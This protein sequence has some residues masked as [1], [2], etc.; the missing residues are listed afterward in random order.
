MSVLSLLS[1]VQNN[2]F[3]L[4]NIVS[5]RVV[6]VICGCE[7]CNIMTAEYNG[8]QIGK[9]CFRGRTK[10]DKSFVLLLFTGWEVCMP[11]LKW[12]SFKNTTIL[13]LFGCSDWWHDTKPAISRGGSHVRWEMIVPLGEARRI[14]RGAGRWEFYQWCMPSC[15]SYSSNSIIIITGRNGVPVSNPKRANATAAKPASCSLRAWVFRCFGLK[16]S[17]APNSGRVRA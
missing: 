4:P 15:L 14:L 7:I 3:V 8:R 6:D 1:L 17:F 12:E 5:I 10:I 2:S 11:F 16:V 13:I 9:D